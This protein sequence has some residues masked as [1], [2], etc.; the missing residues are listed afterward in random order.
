MPRKIIVQDLETLSFEEYEVGL[1]IPSFF[2]YCC[3]SIRFAVA[4]FCGGCHVI[5]RALAS[6]AAS[7]SPLALSWISA[8]FE[9]SAR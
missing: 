4:K 2:S 3:T 6:E 9:L 5:D 7:A 8:H 1:N